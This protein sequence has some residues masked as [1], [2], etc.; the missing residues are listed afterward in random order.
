MQTKIVRNRFAIDETPENL[1][2]YINQQTCWICGKGGWRALSQ[3]LVKAHGLPAAEVR[4]MAYMFKHERLISEELSE[5]LSE[6]ALTKFGKRRHIPLKGISQ[7]PRILSS[8][9]KDIVK[10]K[11][12]IIRPLAAISQRKRRKPH[13]CKMCGKLIETSRPNYCSPEC[14][15]IALANAAKKNMTPERIAHFKSVRYKATSEE[16]RS[17][18]KETWRKIRNWPIEEQ[19]AMFAKRVEN[20]KSPLVDTPCV[21]CGRL[22]Q[23]ALYR[24]HGKRRTT[25]SNECSKYLLAKRARE[26]PVKDSTRVKL[27]ELARIRH[28]GNPLFGK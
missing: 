21:A 10:K 26:R 6:A 12:N 7:A 14:V 22:F 20:R 9:A 24:L 13:Q 11:V 28:I 3:H 8:K 27:S 1:R 2:Q 18:A 19:K 25:C 4:E 16:L 5:I 15:K 23:V 17:R